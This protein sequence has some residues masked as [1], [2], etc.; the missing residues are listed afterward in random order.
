M[1]EPSSNIV[2]KCC[3]F[4]IM[5]LMWLLMYYQIWVYCFFA[6]RMYALLAYKIEIYIVIFNNRS[7]VFHLYSFSDAFWWL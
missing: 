1:E 7:Q 3:I 4:H 6:L 2:T 5:H